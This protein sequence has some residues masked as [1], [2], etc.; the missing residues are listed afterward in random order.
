M[1]ILAPVIEEYIFRKQL[2]DRMHIYGEK[3]AVITSALM[4]G[5][6]H[7]NLSQ[8][9]YAFALGLVF[10]YVYLKTG[11]LRYSIGL[12]MLINLIG[13]VIGPLFLEKIAVLDTM[14]TLDLAA[15]EPIMPW[16]IGFGAYVVV[17]IG[18][19]IAGLVLLCINKRRVSFAP[20]EMELPKGSRF[21]TAYVNV[22]MILLALGCLALIVAS[23]MPL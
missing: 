17:L 12:H 9:F 20:S 4:F 22:G 11:K 10:G 5:L 8:L 14:E 21:K 3:L 19:A 18:L 16:L 6:F 7:G 15:L 13:S 1:V 2:I 23:V